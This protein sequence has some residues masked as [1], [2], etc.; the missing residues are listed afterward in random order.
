MLTGYSDP[1]LQ[2]EPITYDIWLVSN[3]AGRCLSPLSPMATIAVIWKMALIQYIYTIYNVFH[4][5]WKSKPPKSFANWFSTRR[6]PQWTD[7]ARAGN[8]VDKTLQSSLWSCIE[9]ISS[10][11]KCSTEQR[12]LCHSF[13]ALC[14]GLRLHTNE[15]T[16]YLQQLHH[17]S[18]TSQMKSEQNPGTWF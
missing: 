3:S 2:T 5:T 13:H 6:V 8:S 15:I 14:D 9:Y 7:T 11:S 12:Y 18:Q 4:I 16:E 10:N 17:Y 1:L